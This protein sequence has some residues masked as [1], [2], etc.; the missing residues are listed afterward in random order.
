MPKLSELTPGCSAFIQEVGGQGAFRRRLIDMGITSG[1]KVEVVRFAP[2]GDP[3][4]IDIRGYGLSIRKV[5]AEQISVSGVRFNEKKDKVLAGKK[6]AHSQ[7]EVIDK[8]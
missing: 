1:T 8:P 2:F 3:I 7:L 6:Y 4:Q 5:E